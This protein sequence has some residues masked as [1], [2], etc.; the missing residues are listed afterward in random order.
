[1]DQHGSRQP[2]R[3]IEPVLPGPS[4]S[5][6]RLP[7]QSNTVETSP[8][9]Q[10]TKPIRRRTLP[11][12]PQSNSDHHFDIEANSGD[13]YYYWVTRLRHPTITPYRLIITCLTAG[14][15]LSKASLAYRG[16]SASPTTLEWI[17]GVIVTIT[18]FWL[19]LYE[20]SAP[21]SFTWLFEK[22]MKFIFEVNFV[23]K[24]VFITLFAA[25]CITS[26]LAITWAAYTVVE[27]MPLI[28]DLIKACIQIVGDIF[29]LCTI[30]SLAQ[31]DPPKG[32]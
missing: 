1:M 13:D 27:V 24:A 14:F 18:L 23:L 7:I 15:G 9:S 12:S 21:Q 17:F 25:G 2:I 22:D 6:P 16:L 31:K 29:H 28:P 32:N 20:E 10:P 3:H 19:G 11:T 8:S 26:L 4:R 5:P 30:G